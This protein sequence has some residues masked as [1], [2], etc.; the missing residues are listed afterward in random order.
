M[1]LESVL[2]SDLHRL[3]SP[4]YAVV[5]VPEQDAHAE[6]RV[7]EASGFVRPDDIYRSHFIEK[8]SHLR[9]VPLC[10]PQV[11][12]HVQCQGQSLPILAHPSLVLHVSQAIDKIQ[13]RRRAVLGQPFNA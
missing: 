11:Q 4:G 12:L 13:D 5:R 6:T 3:L 2:P 10:V 9:H 7:D 1:V 8:G